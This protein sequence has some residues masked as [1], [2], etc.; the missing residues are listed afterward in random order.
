MWTII[1]TFLK[2]P[3]NILILILAIL[4][5][6]FG[7]V[8]LFQRGSLAKSKGKIELQ[9]AEIES[10]K[11]TQKAYQKTVEDYADQVIKL[12]KLAE[13]HQA[14]SNATAKES[15]KIKYIKSK[16]KLEGGDAQTV[17]NIAAYFNTH[18]RMRE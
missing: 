5:L 4:V 17:N 3:K 10:L 2:N 9:S 18:G 1:L 11:A 12:Q 16:C 8:V 6:T 15:V 14:I 7:T 13:S